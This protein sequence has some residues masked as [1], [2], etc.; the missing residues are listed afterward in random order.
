MIDGDLSDGVWSVAD[1]FTFESE[2]QPSR[3]V[4]VYAAKDNRAHYYAFVLNDATLDAEDAVYLYLDTNRNL[5]DPDVSDRLFIVEREGEPSEQRGIGTNSD[6]LSWE[7]YA[8]DR[9]EVAIATPLPTQWVAEVEIETEEFGGLA[10][11]F[12]MMIQTL[13]GEEIVVWPEGADPANASSWA[14]IDNSVCP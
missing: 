5:G 11:P 7:P 10:D 14:G 2:T 4:R 3:I 12:G 8:G 13:F 6:L 1:N 9:W